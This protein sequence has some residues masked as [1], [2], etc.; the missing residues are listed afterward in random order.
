MTRLCTPALT[1][2]LDGWDS[3]TGAQIADLYIFTL[4]TGEVLYYSGFQ[5]PL[6]APLAN[7]SSP[8]LN[9]QLGPK[10]AR[11]KVKVQIGPQIDELEVAVYAGEDDLVAM[12]S[13]G[14]LTWQKA[15][16]S[17][18]FDGA[19]CELLRAFINVTPGMPP[20][21]EVVGTITWFYGRIG[22]VEIGRT[23]CLVRVKSLLDLL[24]VQMP[25][26][27]FQSACNHV[28]GA[29][30]CGFDRETGIS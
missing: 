8:L 26:R 28:F 11:T 6:L 19:Y 14:T 17:G 30:M 1:T 5:T 12:D 27:L 2:F 23:R 15:F 10:F 3:T 21:M 9:F 4:I 20:T 24:T 13:G 25:R 29:P 18:I 16:W 7:T 22:D